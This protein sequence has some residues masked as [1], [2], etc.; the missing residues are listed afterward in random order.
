MT[1][2]NYQIPLRNSIL[3]IHIRKLLGFKDKR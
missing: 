1:I 3:F 2:K